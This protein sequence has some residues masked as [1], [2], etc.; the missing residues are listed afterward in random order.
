MLPDADHVKGF[1]WI[2]PGPLAGSPEGIFVHSGRTGGYDHAVKIMLF[3]V[4]FHQL[5]SGVRTHEEIITAHHHTGQGCSIF[6]NLLNPDSVGNI[7][8]AVTNIKP[9]PLRHVNFS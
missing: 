2:Q 8:P 5:L 7:D 3:D 9:N 1:V 6:C 4:C